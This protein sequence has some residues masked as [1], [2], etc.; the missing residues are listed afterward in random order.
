M[1][2]GAIETLRSGTTSMALELPLGWPITVCALLAAWLAWVVL[3][4]ALNGLR[5]H[6]L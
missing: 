5:A 4:T 2:I 6:G 1:A 3:L